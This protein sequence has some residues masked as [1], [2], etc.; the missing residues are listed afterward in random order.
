MEWRD[1][2]GT[3]EE[4]DRQNLDY[5]DDAVQWSL[6]LSRGGIV[7]ASAYENIPQVCPFPVPARYRFVYWGVTRRCVNCYCLRY[8]GPTILSWPLNTGRFY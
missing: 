4:D 3:T 2:R 5:D 8:C 1:L 7:E 6:G